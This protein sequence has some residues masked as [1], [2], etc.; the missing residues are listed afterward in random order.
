LIPPRKL[1]ETSSSHILCA[2]FP[3][4]EKLLCKKGKG[5]RFSKTAQAFAQAIGR[6]FYSFPLITF[7]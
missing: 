6:F 4:G 1:P 5:L 3:D 2:R 7:V